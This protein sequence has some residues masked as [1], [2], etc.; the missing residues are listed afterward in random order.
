M[1]KHFLILITFLLALPISVNAA[2]VW[3]VYTD[4]D[5]DSWISIPMESMDQCEESGS[6]LK[7]S[8]RLT[9]TDFKRRGYECIY[10]K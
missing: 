9:N 6:K 8:Q 1:I 7:A 5:D 10:G 3:L 2:G 4:D